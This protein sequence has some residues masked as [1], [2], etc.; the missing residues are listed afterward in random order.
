MIKHIKR[1]LGIGQTPVAPTAPTPYKIETPAET[2]TS[3]EFPAPTTARKP[4]RPAKSKTNQPA[5]DKPKAS[6]KPRT[7]RA[8]KA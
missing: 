8:P 7:P 1:L 4:A 2:T 3:W 5:A 6:R